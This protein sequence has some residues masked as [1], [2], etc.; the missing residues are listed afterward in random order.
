V[1]ASD[2]GYTKLSFVVG[3]PPTTTTTE[4][5]EEYYYA[6]T[7]TLEGDDAATE[8]PSTT[9]ELVGTTTRGA[10]GWFLAA[11]RQNCNEACSGVG[12]TCNEI[13]FAAKNS[14]V[15]SSAEMA[16][17]MNKFSQKCK[18]YYL[19]SSIP[20]TMRT[21][22]PQINPSRGICLVSM[23]CRKFTSF[24]CDAK[25]P[26]SRN[27]RLCYCADPDQ[28]SPPDIPECDTTTTATPVE[29]T[30]TAEK[31][32]EVEE[33][34]TE[35]EETT[36]ITTT[37]TSTTTV[38]VDPS[39][40]VSGYFLLE[41]T[42]V[43]EFLEDDLV[44]QGIKAALSLAFGV[45]AVYIKVELSIEVSSAES[46]NGEGRRLGS[47]NERRLAVGKVRIAYTVTLPKAIAER[48]GKTPVTLTATINAK[49]LKEVGKQIVKAIKDVLPTAKYAIKVES[50][51]AK[52]GACEETAEVEETTTLPEATI[53]DAAFWAGPQLSVL[54]PVACLYIFDFL[55]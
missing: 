6:T 1:P 31:E 33:T 23:E 40:Q 32:E 46:T 27:R 17:F 26:Q 35:E 47:E 36:T 29:E 13:N 48:L 24:S 30:T 25:S 44:K 43:E 52:C 16:F 2:V 28:S 38:Y 53:A 39:T 51:G 42:K 8:A 3:A 41:V 45:P 10:P 14:D 54:V 4:P 49:D 22:S 19:W 11:P 50:G 18:K 7:T 55:R 15:D 21:S 37:T 20:K 12:L 34:T 9:T 5:P